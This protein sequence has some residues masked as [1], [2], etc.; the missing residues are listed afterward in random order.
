MVANLT[1]LV[2][3]GSLIIH[4]VPPANSY[5]QS[6]WSCKW[7]LA[8]V[9]RADSDPDSRILHAGSPPKKK[10][11]K[12]DRS[13][14]RKEKHGRRNDSFP[15]VCTPPFMFTVISCKIYSIYFDYKRLKL[16]LFRNEI[17]KK[18]IVSSNFFVNNEWGFLP[19]KT[20]NITDMKR[21]YIVEL[22]VLLSPQLPLL[23]PS[24]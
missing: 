7:L 19:K 24:L 5:N 13:V 10:L 14:R 8:V 17:C 11:P 22:A 4:H 18:K 2:S 21:A 9:S 15:C 12:V 1:W 3:E 20:S 6:Q 23:D 16:M